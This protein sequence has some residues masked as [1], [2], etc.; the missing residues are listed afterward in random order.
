MTP[1]ETIKNYCLN[2]PLISGTNGEIQTHIFI[3]IGNGFE[4]VNGELVDSTIKTI[5]IEDS[6][7]SFLDQYKD[8]DSLWR[9][10]IL[11]TGNISS[12]IDYIKI[13]ISSVLKSNNIADEDLEEYFNSIEPENR[14][15]LLSISEH[16]KIY[17][18]PSKI[19]KDLN[20]SRTFNVV[21]DEGDLYYGSYE[22]CLIFIKEHPELRLTGDDIIEE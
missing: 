17:K 11:K 8:S 21:F 22:G 13:G 1:K 4:W 9:G 19:T 6:I 15:Y 12:F 14:V 16:S 5:T 18:L 10:A 2:Y 20:R 3:T 7:Y